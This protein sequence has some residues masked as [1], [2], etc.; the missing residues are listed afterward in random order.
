MTATNAP[1]VAAA[2]FVEAHRQ[3]P[4]RQAQSTTARPVPTCASQQPLEGTSAVPRVS[5]SLLRVAHDGHM[6]ITYTRV[7]ALRCVA[8]AG[9]VRNTYTRVKALRCVA[10]AGM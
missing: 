4:A 1:Q 2:S 7:K 5:T 8:H 6:R 10:H 3:G 9:H